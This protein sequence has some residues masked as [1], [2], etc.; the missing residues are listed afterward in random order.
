MQT[1]LAALEQE[2]CGEYRS[3][4]SRTAGGDV[5]SG[6]R[7]TIKKIKSGLRD[8]QGINMKTIHTCALSLS[9]T[10]LSA[11]AMAHA[12]SGAIFTTLSDGSEV[13]LN[14]FPSKQ[15]VYLDGG[16]GPGAPQ[17]AAGLDD[18]TYVFQVTD[19]SGKDL[20]S[21]DLARCRQF[22]VLAGVINS[23]VNTDCEHATGLDNDHGALTVQ[24]MP[25]LDT[26]NQGGVYKVWAI[27]LEDF[28]AGCADLGVANGLD[29]V[30][31][32]SDPGNLHGFLGGHHKTDNFKVKSDPPR[33]IDA[34]F[35]DADTGQILLGRGITWIDTLGG[36][37]RKWSYYKPQLLVFNEAHVEAVE[38]GLH[39]I[40]VAD[41]PGCF[42]HDITLTT[43]TPRSSKSS[44]IGHGAQT[45]WVKV[46]PKDKEVTYFVDIDCHQSE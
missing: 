42:V 22:T 7:W 39:Q 26:T 40:V 10:A 35:F 34:R 15:A 24:L 5:R 32:G 33:E 9:I 11:A 14:Q 46:S 37:N 12:P 31:C 43:V 1:R 29:V 16:P 6:C 13:N 25:Y 17:D 20:L 2:L 18:G 45:V 21:T 41:Q 27:E 36:Q 19:P 38:N 23:V 3:I 44:Y 28:L 30:D 8:L 4:G